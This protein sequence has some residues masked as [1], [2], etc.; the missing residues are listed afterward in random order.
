[1]KT[2]PPVT[3][4]YDTSILNPPNKLKYKDL[5]KGPNKESWFRGMGNELWR[6]AQ[7]VTIQFHGK[8]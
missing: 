7:E 4:Q 2:H 6:L 3:V 5:I 1:M 8:V